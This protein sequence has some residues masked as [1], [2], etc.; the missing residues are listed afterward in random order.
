MGGQM[1]NAISIT[2][3]NGSWSVDYS[4]K[5]WTEVSYDDALRSALD[6]TAGVS[7]A[8]LTFDRSGLDALRAATE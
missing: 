7:G 8:S 3:A 4:G 5:Q 2:S 1:G 6:A